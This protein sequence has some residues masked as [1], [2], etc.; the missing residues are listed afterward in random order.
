M[1]K[2]DEFLAGERLDDVAIFLTH[3]F[4][5]SQG[6]IA[7]MGEAVEGGVVLVVPGDD[8]RA[9]FA[10]GT[11]M[12]PMEFA[13]EAMDGE[14]EIDHGLTGGSCDEGHEV[15]LIFA[16]AEAENPDVGGLYAEGDVMHAYAQC[17]EGHAF[18]EKWIV[19][20]GA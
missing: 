16:F 9:A 2:L 13:R 17:S 3:E 6:R 4:L 12:D 20:D 18:S 5:D 7:N 14:G 8:G 15:E 11:G 1:S 19:G 10:S